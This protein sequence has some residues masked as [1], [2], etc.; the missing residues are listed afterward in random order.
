MVFL[1]LVW[2]STYQDG[3]ATK[4]RIATTKHTKSTKEENIF[5]TRCPRRYPVFFVTFVVNEIKVMVA[6]YPHE[7]LKKQKK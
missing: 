7:S 2:R 6:R 4:V 1:G 5:W 3:A